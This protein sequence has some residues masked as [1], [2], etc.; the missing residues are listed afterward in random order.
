LIV[1]DERLARQKVRVLLGGITDIE[2]IGE[3]A[4]AAAGMAAIERDR[5]DL[6]LLD[7]E[8]PG[9]NGFAM[10]RRLEGA[11][12]PAVIF[13]TAHDEYALQAFEVEA[14]DYVLKPF[15]KQRFGEAVRRAR[16]RIEEGADQ[17]SDARI[18]RLLERVVAEGRPEP[19][20][21]EHFV[22]KERDRTLLVAAAEVDWIEAEGK[23]VRLHTAGGTHLVRQSMS[24]V[25]ERLDVRRFVR[26]H[27]GTIVN[28]KRIAE[29]H[30]GF[31]GSLFVL[32]RDG[33]KLTMSRRYRARIRE[34]TGLEF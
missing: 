26:I 30:D 24:E 15:D 10:L 20:R 29:I 28:L 14:V 32:L 18:R 25:E 23:Y 2:V 16:K 21:L 33:A 12:M 6:V 7:V 3:C 1:D 9:E 4:T 5:P 31:G 22:V 27:R 11:R 19:K 17:E 13:I 8:M 34:L